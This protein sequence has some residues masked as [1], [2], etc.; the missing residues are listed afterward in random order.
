MKYSRYFRGVGSLKGAKEKKLSKIFLLRR[1]AQI[2]TGAIRGVRG[3]EIKGYHKS[4]GGGA[5]G[6]RGHYGG[7]GETREANE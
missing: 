3:E 7:E 6:L 5:E 2:A 4:K 1:E